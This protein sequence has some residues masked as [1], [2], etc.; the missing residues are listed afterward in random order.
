MRILVIGATGTIGRCVVAALTAGNEIVAVSRQ[1][2]AITVDLADP[3]SIREMYRSVGQLDAVACAA[4][5]A[6]F[7]PLVQLSD[8]DFRFC[9]DNKLMGQVNLVRFGFEHV[10]DRGSFT[11]TAGIL[12]RSPTPGSA[13]IS[14]VNAGIEGFVKAAALEAPRGIRV[15]AVSPPWV[16]ETLLALKMDPSQGLPA[17]VVARSYVQSVTGTSTGVILEPSV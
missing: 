8:A 13:A 3:T 5:Q 1:S 4:G 15:N 2:T 12:A 17:A 11:L 10:A 6:K 16:T 7:A 9:L 14:V